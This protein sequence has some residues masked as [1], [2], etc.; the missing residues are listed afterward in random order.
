MKC[1]KAE[2]SACRARW[3]SVG[4]AFK[5]GKL[6]GTR[7]EEAL[8]QPQP[9]VL[10]RCSPPELFSAFLNL[11]RLISSCLSSSFFILQFLKHV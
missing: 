9:P 7:V 6:D 4:A 11:F 5:V 10:C 2:S 8:T 1:R 3:D